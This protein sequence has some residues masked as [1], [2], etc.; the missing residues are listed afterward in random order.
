MN[1]S[2]IALETLRKIEAVQSLLQ[3]GMEEPE[4]SAQLPEAS[5]LQPIAEELLILIAEGAAEANPTIRKVY[6]HH[7]DSKEEFRSTTPLEA[8]HFLKDNWEII[9]GIILTLRQL[10]YL[11]IEEHPTISRFINQLKK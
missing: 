9:Y 5:D 2:E 10:G 8:Y 7:R 4:T 1:S 11:K 6:E 3:Q